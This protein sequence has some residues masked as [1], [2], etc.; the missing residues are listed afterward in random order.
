[1]VKSAKKAIFAILG[2]SA[3]T[4]EELMT[5]FIGAEALI[6][7]RPLTYQT[8]HPRDDV[9][10]T[11]NHFLQGQAGGF[12]APESVDT[13][14]FNPKKRWRRIRELIRHFW[15]RWMKEWIPSLNRRRKWFTHLK[16]N[17]IVL[18]ISPNTP[19]GHWPMGRII[20]TYPGKDGHTR[21]V[22]I[23]IGQTVVT[24]PVTKVCSL[25]MDSIN[26]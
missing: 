11:P 21:V 2:N 7:S 9:P 22:D 17:D 1:M 10:L 13:T 6:N 15:S 20:Q 3:V 25:E 8:A 26:Y 4:D 16:V 12:F 14:P 19:R 24:R 23:Q 5:A 18:V